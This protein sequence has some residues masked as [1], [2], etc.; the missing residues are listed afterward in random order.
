MAGTMILKPYERR[1]DPGPFRRFA[2]LMGLLFLAAFYGLMCS[3]LPMQL[4][5]IPLVPVL[6]MFGL[7]L[8]MLPDIGGIRYDVMARLLIIFAGINVLWPFYV[9]FDAPGLPW[10][11]PARITVGLLTAVVLLH[12][13]MSSDRKSVV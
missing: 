10:I 12:L 8:W 7:I 5:V 13:A 6:I 9:A 4:L 3:I 1:R 11:T 2:A